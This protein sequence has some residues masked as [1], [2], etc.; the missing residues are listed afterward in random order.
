MQTCKLEFGWLDGPGRRRLA[1][2]L[3][4]HRERIRSTRYAEHLALVDAVIDGLD[5]DAKAVTVGPW[6]EL[7]DGSRPLL[8][9]SLATLEKAAVAHAEWMDFDDGGAIALRQLRERLINATG[10]APR[11]QPRRFGQTAGVDAR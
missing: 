5:G 11:T 4:A 1:A 3:V 9:A 8:D 2:A 7:E 10:W 6:P